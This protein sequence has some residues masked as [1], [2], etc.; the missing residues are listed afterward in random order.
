M[1]TY[2]TLLFALLASA[3]FAQKRVAPE[4]GLKGG[5][6]FAMLSGDAIGDNDTRT[7]IHFGALAHIH[8]SD[9]FAL[10]PELMYSAQGAS[11][12]GDQTFR[13]NYLNLPVNLQYM[14]DNG[15]RIQTGPQ[16]GF[17]LS[18]ETENGNVETDVKD[19]LKSIDFAWTAGVGILFESGFGLDV[20]YNFGLSDIT[21]ANGTVRN[22][23]LQTGVFYQFRKK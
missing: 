1:K 18:A 4:Y 11:F 3:S 7:A 5:I 17:L 23:V 21:E 10:Q 2:I 12:E 9:K 6:N 20:R 15:F 16:L 8:L 14:F 19:L 22:N 13:Y